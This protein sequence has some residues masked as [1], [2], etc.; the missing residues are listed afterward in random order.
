MHKF[1]HWFNIFPVINSLKRMNYYGMGYVGIEKPM[2]T[3]GS[4]TQ[5]NWLVL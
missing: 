5:I 4:K 2:I 3:A 1:L